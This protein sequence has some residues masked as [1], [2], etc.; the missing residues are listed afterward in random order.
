MK[1]GSALGRWDLMIYQRLGFIEGALDFSLADRPVCQKRVDQLMQDHTVD[2]ALG[3]CLLR[4]AMRSARDFLDLT[5]LFPHVAPRFRY[6]DDLLSYLWRT[7]IHGKAR[8]F[9]RP[10]VLAAAAIGH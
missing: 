4:H 1:L 10:D 8:G 7:K 6:V 9:E 3:Q 5:C 2:G